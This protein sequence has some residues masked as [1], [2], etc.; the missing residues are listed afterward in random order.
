MWGVISTKTMNELI[1]ECPVFF[2]QEDENLFFECIY[3]LPDYSEVKGV[4]TKLK[5]RFTSE[6]TEIA[7]QQI[8]VL[9]RRWQTALCC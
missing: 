1:I 7:Q 3:N 4:G 5:I 9:C 6:V 8:E 2:G